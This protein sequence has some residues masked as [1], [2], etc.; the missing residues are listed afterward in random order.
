MG[1]LLNSQQLQ[2]FIADG[3]VRIDNAFSAEL[4]SEAR[5]ILWNDLPGN[6]HD[7]AT[8][9]QPVV[10]LGMYNH[11]P[12]IEAANTDVLHHALIS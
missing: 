3:F 5:T 4:A 6:S 9:T 2:S 10:R 8:W 11:S 12:F 1:N 7:P